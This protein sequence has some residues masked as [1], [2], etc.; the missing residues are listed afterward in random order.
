MIAHDKSRQHLEQ[1]RDA[2]RFRVE[3]RK[4]PDES[5]NTARQRELARHGDLDAITLSER[6]FLD[7]H[8]EAERQLR[9][10]SSISTR[11]CSMQ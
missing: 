8:R 5:V 6:L 11:V 4:L 10:L 9:Q 1:G 3:R 2:G 7:I